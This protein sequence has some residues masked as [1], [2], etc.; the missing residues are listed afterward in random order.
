MV[1]MTPGGEQDLLVDDPWR[2]LGRRYRE[3]K[4]DNTLPQISINRPG[5]DTEGFYNR[6][7]K[8]LDLS[9]AGSRLADVRAANA[10]AR[11]RLEEAKYLRDQWGTVDLS[12]ISPEFLQSQG[13]TYEDILGSGKGSSS[14]FG[15]PLR[16]DFRMSSGFKRGSGGS[17]YR[18]GGGHSGMDFAAPAGTPIYATHSGYVSSAGWGGRYGNQVVLSGSGGLGTRYAHA[19]RLAVK[20]GQYIT[21]GQIIG[22]VGSTGNSSGNHLHY[23]VLQ[24]G[25][26][27]NPSSY[28]SGYSGRV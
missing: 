14:P 15:P 12:G 23:E 6:L 5:P 4:R 1:T 20:S 21:R 28:L 9:K 11:R 16:G 25:N 22:Y 3:V 10:E 27:V 18:S 19:S 24:G 26:P 7:A 13:L 8:T 2:Q 17:I